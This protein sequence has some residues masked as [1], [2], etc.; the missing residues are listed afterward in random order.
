L[1]VVACDEPTDTV[2]NSGHAKDFIL[3]SLGQFGQQLQVSLF[4]RD[5]IQT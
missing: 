1:A 4:G 2:G 3:R 5:S